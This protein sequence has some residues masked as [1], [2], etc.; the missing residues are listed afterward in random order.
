MLEGRFID[1]YLFVGL[2]YQYQL[3]PQIALLIQGIL[4]REMTIEISH[5]SDYISQVSVMEGAKRITLAV[6][7]FESFVSFIR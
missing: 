4:A 6:G 3:H 5:S 1:G 2:L 7:L